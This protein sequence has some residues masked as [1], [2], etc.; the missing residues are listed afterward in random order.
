MSE[1]TGQTPSKRNGDDI[2]MGVFGMPDTGNTVAVSYTGTAAA[3]TGLVPDKWYRL[4]CTTDCFVLFANTGD[5]AAGD[6]FMKAGIPEVFY[7]D[8]VSRISAIRLTDSGS[9]YIT[10]IQTNPGQSL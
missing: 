3:G 7:L 9:L 2:L 6:M 4:V 5:A 8:G 10:Q 1:N